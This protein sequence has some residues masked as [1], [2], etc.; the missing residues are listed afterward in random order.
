MKPALALGLALSLTAGPAL[1]TGV[2]GGG[3]FLT[4]GKAA[5]WGDLTWTP[6]STLAIAAG[7]WGSLDATLPYLAH[8]KLLLTL[9]FSLDYSTKFLVAPYVGYRLMFSQG[10][11][12]LSLGGQGPGIGLRLAWQP[13]SLPLGTDVEVAAYPFMGTNL[14][15]LDYALRL[16]YDILPVLQI[17]AG[18]QG[19][20]G[21]FNASGPVLGGRL[22]F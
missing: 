4:N 11:G 18:Y 13:N 17:L 22:S 15:A 16:T 2:D 5:F 19:Y 3:Q 10:T 9:P 1:A 14:N 20:A 8:G 6:T 12:G 21:G 7:G